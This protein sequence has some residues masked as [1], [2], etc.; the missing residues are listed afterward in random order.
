MS[1]PTNYFIYIYLFIYLFIYLCIYTV[2]MVIYLFR[3]V[4]NLKCI[5]CNSFV[6]VK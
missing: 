3:T 2:V 4:F 1:F 5:N 6:R